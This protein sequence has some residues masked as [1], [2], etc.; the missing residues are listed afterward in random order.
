MHP[1]K[2]NSKNLSNYRPTFLVRHLVFR[3][4]KAKKLPEKIQSASL[5]MSKGFQKLLITVCFHVCICLCAVVVA[6]VTKTT[7]VIL[8]N[9]SHHFHKKHFSELLTK[10]IDTKI[11]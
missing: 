2:E 7:D 8:Y 10:L 4:D 6:A 11:E 9:H 5:V 1:C 3:L